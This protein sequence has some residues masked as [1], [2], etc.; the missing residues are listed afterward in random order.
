[1]AAALTPD[2]LQDDIAV[3]L[4]R[5]VAAANKKA[6]ELGVDVPNSAIN[7]ARY[8]RNGIQLWRVNY[9][10]EDYI[11]RRGGDVIIEVNPVDASIEGV[12]RGQ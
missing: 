8:D 7:I 10:P 3:S 4:A 1:M 2:V 5:V 11:S 6:V 9:G 12:L